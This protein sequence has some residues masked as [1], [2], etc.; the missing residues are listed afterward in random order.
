MPQKN[1][2]MTENVHIANTYRHSGTG[3][4]NNNP[5]NYGNTHDFGKKLRPMLKTVL[6]TRI[7]N[8]T[9]YAPYDDAQELT[10]IVAPESVQ[11]V[12]SMVQTIREVFGLSVAQTAK[13][14]G[15]SRPSLYNHTSEKEKPKDIGAYHRVYNLAIE[16]RKLIPSDLK[17]GLKSVLVDGKTLLDYL[18]QPSI[19]QEK[20][21]NIALQVAEYLSQRPE[22]FTAT[23]LQD[24]RITSRSLSKSN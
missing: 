3:Q 5:S 2:Y 11:T 4:Q 7:L 6:E 17:P 12:N 22:P 23:S 21:V 13:V 18:K 19:T 9:Y 1:T 24:Q 20:F 8:G 15:V 16:V 14:V 10:Q